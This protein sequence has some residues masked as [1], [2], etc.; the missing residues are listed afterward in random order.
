MSDFERLPKQHNR[1]SQSKM[2]VMARE[3]ATSAWVVTLLVLAIAFLSFA[4]MMSSAQ[5]TEQS[6][7]ISE[8]LK[9]IPVVPGDYL[10]KMRKN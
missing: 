2:T 1:K 3:S 9:R 5:Q 8:C 6:I 10:E 4:M 7:T